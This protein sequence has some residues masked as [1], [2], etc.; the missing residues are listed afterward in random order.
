MGDGLS[1]HPH[2]E[3]LGELVDGVLEIGVGFHHVL[4]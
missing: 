3:L 4:N 1:Y 2:L